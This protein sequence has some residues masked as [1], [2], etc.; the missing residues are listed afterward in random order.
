MGKF[1][2][3]VA[4][5]FSPAFLADAEALGAQ[6]QPL[7]EAQTR[8]YLAR[9]VRIKAQWEEAVRDY[10]AERDAA[11]DAGDRELA[12]ACRIAMARAENTGKAA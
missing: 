9:P 7:I 8:A 1:I 10:R 4:P 11:L 3:D 5:T 2:L 12:H 6:L